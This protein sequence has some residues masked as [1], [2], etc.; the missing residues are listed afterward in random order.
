VPAVV[1]PVPSPLQLLTWGQLAQLAERATCVSEVPCVVYDAET[2]CFDGLPDV[3]ASV[4]ATAEITSKIA[5]TM[6]NP[7]FSQLFK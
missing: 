1:Q 2:T 6:G 5:I 3:T 7:I 4:T